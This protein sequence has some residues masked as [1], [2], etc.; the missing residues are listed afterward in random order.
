MYK[1]AQGYWSMELIK[2]TESPLTN[3]ISVFFTIVSS[4]CSPYMVSSASLKTM[5]QCESYA[6]KRPFISRAPLNL[7][8]T[9]SSSWYLMR[10]S[11]SSCC[12]SVCMVDIDEEACSL[13]WKSQPTVGTGQS[14]EEPTSTKEAAA[15]GCLC[16]YRENR[17]LI[18]RI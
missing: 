4:S 9:Y 18:F 11:G 6:C 13:C 1:A 16:K 8:S 7:T 12:C 15:Y 2:I 17:R 10:S 14:V 3:T 5:L